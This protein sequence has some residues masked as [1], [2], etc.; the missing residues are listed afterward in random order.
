MVWGLGY[1]VSVKDFKSP[2]IQ[3][4]GTTKVGKPYAVFGELSSPPVVRG[5]E[6]SSPVVRHANYLDILCRVIGGSA[7]NMF[8]QVRLTATVGPPGRPGSKRRVVVRSGRGFAC[9]G[10]I[11]DDLPEACFDRSQV[12]ADIIRPRL[13][14]C[15]SFPGAPRGY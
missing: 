8:L 7:M 11:S 4:C 5:L 2:S 6:L 10:L 14:V 3:A 1:D 9:I 13:R 15:G 12:H